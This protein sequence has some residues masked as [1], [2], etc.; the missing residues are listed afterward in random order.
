M[1]CDLIIRSCFPLHPQAAAASLA[2][3]TEGVVQRAACRHS[4]ETA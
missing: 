1:I 3:P 2:E 4:A